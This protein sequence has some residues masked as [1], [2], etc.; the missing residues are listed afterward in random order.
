MKRAIYTKA[1][2]KQLTMIFIFPF[3]NFQMNF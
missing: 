1:V 3:E 2:N